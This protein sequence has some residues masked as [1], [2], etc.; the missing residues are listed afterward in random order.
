MRKDLEMTHNAQDRGGATENG[1]I[2]RIEARL[3]IIIRLLAL[4]VAPDNL[5]LKERAV[6]LQHVGM[7]PKDIAALCDT[8]PN[9][10]SVALSAA[11]REAKGKKKAAA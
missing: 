2:S 11:K 9:A 4:G 7:A 10:V 1:H 8:T 6:R 3:N 5:T